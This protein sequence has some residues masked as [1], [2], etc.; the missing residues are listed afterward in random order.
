MITLKSGGGPE[1]PQTGGRVSLPAVRCPGSSVVERVLGKHEVASSILV[2]GSLVLFHF[3]KLERV[4]PKLEGA[5]FLYKKI[6]LAGAVQVRDGDLGECGAGKE[7]RILF[8]EC[9]DQGDAAVE[10][11]D[12]HPAGQGELAGGAIRGSD[13]EA[14][15]RRFF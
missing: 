6:V 10:E 7:N 2:Q 15:A 3:L 14:G 12:G 5:A 8:R 4:L 13:A 1:D 11:L 9:G